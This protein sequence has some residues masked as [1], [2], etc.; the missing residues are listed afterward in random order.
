MPALGQRD[1]V[2]V[3]QAVEP[4]ED[5]S[6]LV[7]HLA[8]QPVH[9]CDVVIPEVVTDLDPARVATVDRNDADTRQA[10]FCVPTFGYGIGCS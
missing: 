4:L 7:A 9:A 5:E 1:L 2:T 3:L 10:E 6:G 8:G